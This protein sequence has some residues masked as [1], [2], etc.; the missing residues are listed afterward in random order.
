MLEPTRGERM[1]FR[2]LLAE[3]EASIE[4]VI[5]YP[6]WRAIDMGLEKECK[7]LLKKAAWLLADARRNE[8]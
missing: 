1:D 3:L 4:S 5:G 2:D 8:R 7:A 6:R